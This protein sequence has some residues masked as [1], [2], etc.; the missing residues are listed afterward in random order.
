MWNL[1]RIGCMASEEMPFENVDGRRWR[2]T[3]TDACLHYKLTYEPSAQVSLKVDSVYYW[4]LE[5]IFDNLILPTEGLSGLLSFYWRDTVYFKNIWKGAEKKHSTRI[6]KYLDPELQCLLKFKVNLKL[7][8]ESLAHENGHLEITEIITI[9]YILKRTLQ[10]PFV[11]LSRKLA[12][13]LNV[14]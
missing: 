7:P 1:V 2:T 8:T 10:S 13:H 12:L 9:S 11:F 4:F 3:T 6:G 14:T 5:C